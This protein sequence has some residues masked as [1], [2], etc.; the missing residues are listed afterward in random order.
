M[1]LQ[2]RPVSSRD[3]PPPPAG[4][5]AGAA[6]EGSTL[7]GRSRNLKRIEEAPRRRHV[8]VVAT[9]SR[10]DGEEPRT[11]VRPSAGNAL[12]LDNAAGRPV[13]ERRGAVAEPRKVS[14][15]TDAETTVL[16]RVAT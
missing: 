4:L 1:A 7:T 2:A 8:R 6:L 5:L 16:D 12:A 10:L 14:P 9:P 13:L 15:G 11:V 3:V